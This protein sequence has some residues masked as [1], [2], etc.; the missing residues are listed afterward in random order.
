VFL[1]I[2]SPIIVFVEIALDSLFITPY[3]IAVYL[4]DALQPVYVFFGLAC[5]CGALIGITGR[6]LV[7]ILS[8]LLLGPIQQQ[9]NGTNQS[10]KKS[11]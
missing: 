11:V 6:V 10:L 9:N 7:W 3:N 5:L 1:Y 2:F 4:F 8:T